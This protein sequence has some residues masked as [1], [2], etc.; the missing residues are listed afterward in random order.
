VCVLLLLRRGNQRR[1][2]TCCTPI[3]S[4]RWS[5]PTLILVL[6]SP[7]FLVLF[8][9]GSLLLLFPSFIPLFLI[10]RLGKKFDLTGCRTVARRSFSPFA[11]SAARGIQCGCHFGNKWK[12]KEPRQNIFFF[13]RGKKCSGCDPSDVPQRIFGGRMPFSRSS[14]FQLHGRRG[15]RVAMG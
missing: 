4:C 1:R 5:P 12:V 13:G 7:S 3:Y 10:I 9:F 6:S 15:T 14:W 11:E 8:L 2:E